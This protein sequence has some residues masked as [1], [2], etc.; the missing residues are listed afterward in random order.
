[1]KAGINMEKLFG[2]EFYAEKALERIDAS[3]ER[4]LEDGITL[5]RIGLHNEIAEPREMQDCIFGNPEADIENWH[6]QLES[7]SCAVACQEYIAEQLLD[8]DFSEE[9]MIDFAERKGWYRPET[10]TTIG[11]IGKLLE[12]MGLEV[13]RGMQ[14]SVSDLAEELETD[15]KVIVGVNNMILENPEYADFPGITANHAV[16]VIGIDASD[17]ENISVIL[18]DPGGENGKGRIIPMKTF[19]R[20]WETSNNYAAIARKGAAV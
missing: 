4:I 5:E 18:N 17:P 10:G 9:K 3:Q 8:S 1:L 11:D 13:E 6:P 16:Q 7:N 12:S 15:G 19:Q 2:G 14:Y 20:A